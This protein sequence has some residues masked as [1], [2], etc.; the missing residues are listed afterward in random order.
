MADWRQIQ[1]RIRKAKNSLDPAAKLS[2]LYQR[3]RDGMVAW[4]IGAVE[5][6]N[7]RSDEA[8][9]WYK[10]AADKFR[11]AD[12]KKKAEDALARLG[13]E[14]P[15]KQEVVGDGSELNNSM[16]EAEHA[17]IH[18]EQAAP[19]AVGEIVEDA[20]D[21]AAEDEASQPDT[22]SANAQPGAPGDGARKKRRR[23]RRGGRGRRRKGNA[24]AAPSLPAQAFA[25]SGASA[26]NS[27]SAHSPQ[28]IAATATPHERVPSEAP[29]R[30]SQ[31]ASRPQPAYQP[32]PPQLPSE[33]AAHG[34][35]DPA[36]SSRMAHLESLLRRLMQSPLHH[37]GEADE[38][39]AGPG[40]FLLSEAD[41]SS[42]YYVE[43]CQTLRVGVG[44][45]VRGVRAQKGNR[46]RFNETNLK[47][48]LAEYLGVSEAKVAQYLKDHCVV[49]WIQLDEE[50]GNLAHFA[51]GILRTPLN[52]D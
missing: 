22:L 30:E 40:V 23:G 44:N 20:D 49:R 43:C 33:R 16:I 9:K 6:K 50:A 17:D 45:L 37:L 31:R 26:Q 10:V 3:T 52:I 18:K 42:S 5:E 1:A 47:Q 36:L 41:Q 7:G 24:S 15:E 19:L 13:V 8:V 29:Q 25:S 2:D 28:P 14:A 38:A 48:Q 12:W 51:I 11:R 46:G 4:E 27:P 35:S 32:Q 34:R 39:P 21:E